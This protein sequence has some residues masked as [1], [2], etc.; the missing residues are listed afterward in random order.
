MCSIFMKNC[1]FW[2]VPKNIIDFR[3]ASAIVWYGGYRISNNGPFGWSDGTTFV[4]TNWNGGEPNNSW[5]VENCLERLNI[6]SWN[7]ARCTN[8]QLYICKLDKGELIWKAVAISKIF[9]LL[10]F[11]WKR[12]LKILKIRFLISVICDNVSCHSENNPLHSFMI[13]FINSFVVATTTTTTA[14]TTTTTTAKP[15]LTY[16]N[17]EPTNKDN[18]KIIVCL[19]LEKFKV[20]LY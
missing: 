11:F 20:P 13:L 1:I 12:L 16:I 19:E 17:G 18:E 7:D 3:I 6:G 10:S 14:A 2:K 8:T 15:S 5:G 4:W 9:E